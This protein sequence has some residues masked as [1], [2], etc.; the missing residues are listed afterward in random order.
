M[1]NEKGQFVKGLTPWNKGAKGKQV[2][3]NKGTKG[4]CKPNKGS[5]KMGDKP[6]ITAFKKGFT[7]WNKGV[8]WSE[9]IKEQW[10][11][12]RM[13]KTFNSGRTHFK[14][15]QIP[16]NYKGGIM[17]QN[18]LLK[19]SSEYKRWRVEVFK[20]DSWTCVSCGYR[21]KKRGDINADHKLPFS[22]FPKERLD[23]NNGQTLC[24]P[25]HQ[26]TSS[27]KNSKMKAGDFII[28]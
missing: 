21:S 11:R 4:V 6:P 23:V 16:W 13:G 14:K 9:E 25:C 20:R 26:L 2:A 22:L 10:S 8:P 5:F 3:W 19:G 7:S 24:V 17:T 12:E 28:G 18:Q 1:R 27:Y 15:G